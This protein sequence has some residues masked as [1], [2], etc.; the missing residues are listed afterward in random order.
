MTPARRPCSAPA[1]SA[2]PRHALAAFVTSLPRR[3]RLLR[4]GLLAEA[5]C[6]ETYT[7]RTSDGPTRRHAVLAF[8]TRDGREARAT[9]AGPPAA[10]VAGDHVAVR[11]GPAHPERAVF[12][13]PAGPGSVVGAVLVLVFLTV[14]TVFTAVTT[15]FAVAGAALTG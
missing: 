13:A 8:T 6:L 3:R 4:T 7:T 9:P 5:R 10:L 11:Y 1:A 2:P 15:A 14:F 12:A